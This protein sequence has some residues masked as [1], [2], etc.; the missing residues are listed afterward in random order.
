MVAWFALAGIALSAASSSAGAA[1]ASA[2][3][4]EG[5][6]ASADI[7]AMN[8]NYQRSSFEK[9]LGLQKSFYEAGVASLPLYQAAMKNTLDVT[10]LPLYQMQKRIMDGGQDKDTPQYIKNNALLTLGA[11]EG[12]LAK[13]RLADIQQI[14]LGQAGSAG[15]SSVNFGSAFANSIKREGNA[16]AQGQLSASQEN[17]GMW[18]KAIDDTLSVAPYLA[19]QGRRTNQQ[20]LNGS[21]YTTDFQGRVVPVA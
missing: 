9:Q 6:Q 19:S 13:T 21:Q 2:S 8:R 14:G 15:Q 1:A 10:N 16:Q 7:E 4:I 20:P 12:E 17:Q 11:Q 18:N 3:S 5:A